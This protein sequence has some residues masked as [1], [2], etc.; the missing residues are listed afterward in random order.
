MAQP[1]VL[2]AFS[3]VPNKIGG[4]ESLAVEI[5]RQLKSRGRHLI[6]CFEGPPTP[7]VR[8]Y[9]LQSGNVTIE[10]FQRQADLTFKNA[11]T[12]YRLVRKYK[13]ESVLY[14]LGGIVRL[15]PLIA[16]AMGVR[17]VVYNDGTSRLDMDYRSPFLLRLLMRPVTDVVCVSE[18]IRSCTEREGFVAHSKCSVLYNSVPQGAEFGDGLAFRQRYGI[19]EDRILVLKISWLVPDK[20]IDVALKACREALRQRKDLHFVFC[21]DGENRPEYQRLSAEWGLADHVTWTGQ[22]EDLRTSGAFPA[23]DIQI[24]CSQWHEAFCLAVAEGMS[25][26]L[27]VIASRIGG[28]P[29]LVVDSGNGYLFDPGDYP[30]LAKKIVSLVENEDLRKRMGEAGQQR[31]RDRFNLTRNV[32][33]WMRTL[34]PREQRINPPYGTGHDRE[35]IMLPNT[36]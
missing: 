8:T 5:A 14:A 19:P 12:F 36:P 27:P 25:A 23:A 10:I 30:V 15:W 35:D 7:A 18:F 21:G 11:R 16:R 29:E 32:H 6:L 3:I 9:L 31:A 24:Q 17:R 13:P 4:R 20:G 22:I 26:G 2:C 1:N 34:L 33:E 28:L